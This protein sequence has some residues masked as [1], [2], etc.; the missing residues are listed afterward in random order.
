MFV[1]VFPVLCPM[2]LRGSLNSCTGRAVTF[3]GGR[4]LALGNIVSLGALGSSESGFVRNVRVP[5]ELGH[6]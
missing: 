4:V 6:F 1:P 3:L 2:S 5:R